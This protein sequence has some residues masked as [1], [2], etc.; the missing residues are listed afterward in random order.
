MHI[1]SWLT[2]CCYPFT[3]SSRLSLSPSPTPPPADRP[4]PSISPTPPQ[5]QPHPFATNR[6]RADPPSAKHLLTAK[7]P[8]EPA[9]LMPQTPAAAARRAS[10]NA[11][12][13][14]LSA[15]Q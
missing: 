15:G 9:E 14:P 5:P 13:L 6:T 7:P 8:P 10:A 1:S 4:P 2:G 3:P 11:S 12:S